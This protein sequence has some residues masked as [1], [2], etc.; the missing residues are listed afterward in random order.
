MTRTEVRDKSIVIAAGAQY[1]FID[2][3]VPSNCTI[4][5]KAFGNDLSNVAGWSLVHWQFLKNGMGQYPLD[6]TFDQIGY[7]ASRQKVQNI[8]F[9]GGSR[10]QLRGIANAGTP[11]GCQVL[12]SVEYDIEDND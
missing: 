8:R 5:I 1:D 7:A 10:F 2:E 11:V 12:I 4:V 9:E 6:D 3:Y